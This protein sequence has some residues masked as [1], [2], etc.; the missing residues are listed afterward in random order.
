MTKHSMINLTAK[1]D[2]IADKESIF[3][4]GFQLDRVWYSTPSKV[5]AI[6]DVI[7][8]AGDRKLYVYKNGREYFNVHPNIHT[9]TMFF[10]NDDSRAKFHRLPDYVTQTFTMASGLKRRVY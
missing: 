1:L 4:P 6:Y 2:A 9:G 3:R 10:V 5:W 7:N 8:P